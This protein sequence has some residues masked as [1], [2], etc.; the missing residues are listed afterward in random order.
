MAI[1]DKSSK[2]I[3]QGNYEYL[4]G[5]YHKALASFKKA[6]AVN[7][8]SVEAYYKLGL[9]CF[10]LGL[11]QEA[12]DYL[13]QCTNLDRSNDTALVSYGRLLRE[14]GDIDGSMRRYRLAFKANPN[15]LDALA[16]MAS[17]HEYRKDFQKAL[18]TILPA[19]EQG[20]V[21]AQIAILFARICGKTNRCKQAVEYINMCIASGKIADKDT[22]SFLYYALGDIYDHATQY[23]K[24]FA[25]YQQANQC[26][27]LQYNEFS[28]NNQIRLLKETFSY[29]FFLERNTSGITSDR[30]V[31]VVGMPRS[32]TSLTEQI[33]SS[34][35]EVHGA[36]ELTLIGD[37]AREINKKARTQKDFSEVLRGL[38]SEQLNAYAQTYLDTLKSQ[39]KVA[40]YVTDKMPHNY[41]HLG[42][43][44]MLFPNSRVIHCK[45]NP[46]DTC[47]SIYFKSFNDSHDYATDL[48]ALAHHYRAY[49]DLMQHWGSVLPLQIHEINYE[50]IVTNFRAEVEKMLAFCSL[51]W[52]DN[53]ASFYKTK[54]HVATASEN[55]VSRPIYRSSLARWKNYEKHI[56]PL[57]RQLSDLT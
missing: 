45:R 40:R 11:I 46:I 18:N 2:H 44:S 39:D 38:S 47:L 13:K 35:P 20:I 32:G 17:I 19:C 42:L 33:L 53:C 12:C 30:P 36:G 25:A 43:I 34:H 21:N 26:R 51:D 16:G 9:I 14:A 7:G 23:D 50:D 29:A 5:D 24:A 55:Q 15:N 31:F 48:N 1:T 27:K 8:R 28:H 52:H 41:L 37:I 6:I 22:L 4:K 56:E 49:H 3:Q 10:R 54:R 57:I